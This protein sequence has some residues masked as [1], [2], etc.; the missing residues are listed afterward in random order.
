[1]GLCIAK[2]NEGLPHDRLATPHT[3]TSGA[4][5]RRTASLALQLISPEEILLQLFSAEELVNEL[6]FHNL[7][8][9][10]KE[11]AILKAAILQTLRNDPARES[12]RQRVREVLGVLGKVPGPSDAGQSTVAESQPPP[13][14]GEA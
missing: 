2:D 14:T 7:A 5:L 11:R 6:L 12:L 4:S 3:R 1:M 8:L 13:P 9:T 10:D